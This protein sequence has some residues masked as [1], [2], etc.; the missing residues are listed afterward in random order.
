[1]TPR[2]L[3][4]LVLSYYKEYGRHTL[5]WRKTRDPYKILI[6]EVMLQQTQVERVIPYYGK[7]LKRFPSVQTLSDA[8]LSDVL[9]VWQGLGYNRRA[10]MLHEAARTVVTEYGGS[11][12]K[13]AVALERLPGVG[14][15]TAGAV[16]AFAYNEDTLLLETNIRTVIVHHC[17]Q[18][19]ESVADSEIRTVLEKA[20]PKGMAREWQWALM[21]YG[22]HLKRNG[23]RT[24]HKVR[25]YVKQTAFKG[26][27]REARGAILRTLAAGTKRS[28]ST[29]LGEERKEQVSAELLKLVRE[30][31]V[32]K[33]N[34]VYCLKD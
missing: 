1:M 23:V 26:S 3:R 13:T 9:R 15:Y 10:K 5:P 4:T 24:N 21:D 20:Q 6:S 25:G 14:P 32:E 2:K 18:D 34:G 31:L 22:S 17:F 33:R 12:P 19:Q 8:P 27:S 29:I 30:G 7:F 11:F 16:A 28:L